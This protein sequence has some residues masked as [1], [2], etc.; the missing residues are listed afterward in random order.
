MAEPSASAERLRLLFVTQD[1]PFYVFRF[2]EVFFADYPRAEF[3][4]VGVTIGRAFRE[5]RRATAR[6]MLDFYGPRDFVRV[7][8]RYARVS[9]QRRSIAALARDHGIPLLQ[10]ASVNSPDYVQRVHE[11]ETDVL[12]S[13]AAPEIFHEALL[14][15]PR[16]GAVNIHS[17]RLPRYRGMM[18]VFWQLLSRETHVT[19]TVHEMVRELDAGRVLATRDYPL[20]K[21]DSLDRVMTET[22][23]EG[24]SLMIDVLRDLRA[25]RA[26]PRSLPADDRSYFSFP[27][28]EQVAEFRRIGHR[29]L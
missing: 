27:S 18:P 15:A 6:R 12:V 26:R 20:R 9:L 22:K 2:F 24:A 28:K 16:M 25:G 14:A 3:D 11:L 13:V 21:E 4:V 10:T 17:G 23:R 19:I 7:A 1:D 8:T 29:L 5:S